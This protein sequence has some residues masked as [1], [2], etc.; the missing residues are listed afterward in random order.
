MTKEER[1]EAYKTALKILKKYFNTGNRMC[2]ALQEAGFTYGNFKK[3]HCPEMW[4]F[5]PTLDQQ[6]D[7]WYWLPYEDLQTRQIILDFCIEMT[8]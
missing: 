4:L 3:S 2:F 7:W 8:S 5:V 6:E 1:H